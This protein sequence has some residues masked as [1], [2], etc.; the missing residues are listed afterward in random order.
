MTHGLIE[1]AKTLDIRIC[2]QNVADRVMSDPSSF[3]LSDLD[4][5]QSGFCN[6]RYVGFLEVFKEVAP[7][8]H[9]NFIL[10]EY[11]RMIA[12]NPCQA[13]RSSLQ[14]RYA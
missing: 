3:D 10:S 2:G 11:Q 13:C 5:I 14:R 1:K 8:E 9:Q 7:L 4:K 12:L 6:G